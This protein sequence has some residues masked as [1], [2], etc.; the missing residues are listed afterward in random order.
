MFADGRAWVT[1]R[2][3]K[4]VTGFVYPGEHFIKA[5]GS[6]YDFAE[7][8]DGASNGADVWVADDKS[9]ITEIEGTTGRLV[10]VIEGSR[11]Q[12]N[13]PHALALESGTLWVLN[14][15]TAEMI[16]AS[17]G[18]FEQF[19]D[20]GSAG[21]QPQSICAS[22]WGVWITGLSTVIY[23]ISSKTGKVI[24][25]VSGKQG[26]FDA[27]PSI[28]CDSQHVWLVNAPI[29]GE[30]SIVELKA[31]NGSYVRTI[32][33]SGDDINDS[34]SISSNGSQVWIGNLSSSS[35]SYSASLAGFDA[36]TGKLI[37]LVPLK[38]LFAQPDY[39]VIRGGMVWDVDAELN[40]ITVLTASTG[41]ML[42]VIR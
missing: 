8:T 34:L 22:R 17:S 21:V 33:P 41:A 6:R 30:G 16:S 18:A 25:S 26:H 40:Q 35:G 12:L 13:D 15:A 29:G 19:V 1:D 38:G 42:R 2:L 4:D 37:K 7:P 31:S 32:R 10:R 36:E 23:E 24:R 28:A 3:G 20:F 5:S 11:Y 27:H 14:G 9:Q 39:V